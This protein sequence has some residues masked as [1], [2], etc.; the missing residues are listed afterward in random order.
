MTSPELPIHIDSTMR[1]ALITCPQRFYNE[2]VLNLRPP[3]IAI[4]LHAGGCFST[5]L[6]TVYKSIWIRQESLALA[7]ERARAAFEIHWGD[8][9]IPEH[10][11]TT[12]T[13]DRVWAAVESYFTEYPPL[14][15]PVRPYFD[16]SGK[17]TFE[18]TFAIPLE[19]TAQE[20]DG[21]SFPVHPSGDSFLY[22]GRFD[23]LGQMG[24]RPVVRDE[25]TTGSA[26]SSTWADYWTMRGQFIGY[27]WACRQCGLDVR[28]VIVRG[29]KI[30]KLDI[31][32]I[33]CEKWYD[34]ALIARWREQLRRDL[35]RL[36][37]SWDSGYWDRNFG[38]A[39]T[40][41]GRI[42]SYQDLCTSEQPEL[43]YSNFAPRSWNPLTKNPVGC[44]V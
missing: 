33:E 34:D 25:K 35:W 29:V 15:D 22:C 9:E 1:S 42:C 43:Y 20:D 30:L 44:L 27:V 16:S 32:H 26:F 24:T 40:S 18:Y 8:F 12:K 7:L 31:G 4:D 19:P 38:D 17:P 21:R 28:S 23:M 3:G 11:R 5:A 13:P 10:S 39:C 41:Y 14:S 2:F 36:R 6:E 37:R